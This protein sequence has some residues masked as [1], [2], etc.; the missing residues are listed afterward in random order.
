M[1]KIM[2]LISFPFDSKFIIIILILFC[3]NI[4]TSQQIYIILFSFIFLLLV[5]NILKRPR[6]YNNNNIIKNGYVSSFDQYSFPSGHTFFSYIFATIISK[7]FNVNIMWMPYLVGFSRI[8]LGVH[9]ITDVIGGLILGY[10]I[11]LYL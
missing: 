8:Y 11:S 7:K 9:Y 3:Y 2:N 4:I 10:I 6:P 5:K 1:I